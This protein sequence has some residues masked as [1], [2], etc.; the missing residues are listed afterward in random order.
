MLGRKVCNC[1]DI[2]RERHVR[3]LVAGELEDDDLVLAAD[4]ERREPDIACKP[5]IEPRLGQH[6]MHQR[7]R[8][9]FALCA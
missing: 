8:R 3:G 4:L 9:R 6:Q 1:C 5:G 2:W 7:R